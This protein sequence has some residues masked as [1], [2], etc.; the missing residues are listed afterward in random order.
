MSNLIINDHRH[1]QDEH[2]NI[3]KTK[4]KMIILL[5]VVLV[6]LVL[7]I[8]LV[9]FFINSLLSSAC[10]NEV[11]SQVNQPD[12]INKAVLFV[13]DCGATTRESYQ[14]TIIKSWNNIDNTDRGNTF[15]SY[16]SS[17]IK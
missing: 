9:F 3:R 15:I 6:T 17:D 7:P 5:I 13:R 14:V 2:E 16:T 12:G 4:K 1:V 10:K 11:V 8:I